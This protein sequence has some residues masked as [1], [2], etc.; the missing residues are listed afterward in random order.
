MIRA[1]GHKPKFLDRHKWTT[2]DCPDCD[3]AEPLR[4]ALRIPAFVRSYEMERF[5]LFLDLSW[6][7]DAT[8]YE[9]SCPTFTFLRQPQPRPRKRPRRSPIQR[10]RCERVDVVVERGAVLGAVSD[11]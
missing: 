1:I 3:I 4:S 2:I 7:S 5:V 8:F 11:L 9:R 6:Q 10:R